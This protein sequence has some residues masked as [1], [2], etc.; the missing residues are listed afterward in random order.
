MRRLLFAILLALAIGVAG[1]GGGDEMGSAESQEAPETANTRA[2]NEDVHRKYKD[3]KQAETPSG[4]E[5]QAKEVAAGFY[6][7]LGEDKAQGDA[8]KAMIDSESFCDLMSAEAQ[9]QTVEYAKRTSGVARQW[10]CESAVD[11]LALRAKRAGVAGSLAAAEVIGVNAV[12]D[13]ATA[14]IRFGN[15]AATAVPL[16]KEDGEW[17]LATSPGAGGR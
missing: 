11:L 12:G 15:G 10:D 13:H 7:I 6:E 8:N 16:V 17:K 5:Q 14:T 9:E 1:C 4:D 3:R 2:L